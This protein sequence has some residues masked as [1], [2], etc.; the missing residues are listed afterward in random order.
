MSSALVNPKKNSL[1][2]KPLFPF[3]LSPCTGFIFSHS[4]G[5]SWIGR[6]EDMDIEKHIFYM[7][8][9]GYI[10]CMLPYLIE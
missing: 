5:S 6:K 4:P 9:V 7:L 10:I 3:H 8:Y 1:C 2:L